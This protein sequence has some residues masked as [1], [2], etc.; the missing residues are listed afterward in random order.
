MDFGKIEIE[1]N[2]VEIALISLVLSEG[3]FSRLQ[4][5]GVTNDH[6]LIWNDTYQF[7]VDYH[8]EYGNVPSDDTITFSF[9]DFKKSKHENVDHDFLIDALKELKRKENVKQLVLKANDSLERKSSG[10]VISGLISELGDISSEKKTEI[11]FA[12]GD[13]LDDIELYRAK[14]ELRNKGQMVGIPSGISSLDNSLMGFLDGDFV[15]LMGPPEI[16]KSWCMLKFALEAYVMGH[17]VMMVSLEMIYE[18]LKL[19]W[20]T[21]LGN[22]YG[23]KFSNQGLMSGSGINEQE[24]K[25]FLKEINGKNNFAIVDDLQGG[26]CT[27]SVLEGLVKQY[28]PKVLLIDSLPLMTASDGGLAVN[29]NTLLEV[30]YAIKFL[31]NRKEIVTIASMISSTETFNTT[32][33]P[34]KQDMGLGKYVVYACDIGVSMSA[35]DNPKLR[36]VRLFKKRKGTPNSEITTLQF[37]PNMG[38]IKE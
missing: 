31:T 5:E 28:E 30:A 1:S 15:V 12:D 19:R 36:R 32:T 4:V 33:P 13:V 35:A 24:Y 29:W 18:E 23:Y 37:D 34:E 26:A 3:N 14:K 27:V 10:D 17:K 20:H 25:K 8:T 9:P 38:V 16:G 2:E 7:I 6:F 21:L 22:Y 11:L